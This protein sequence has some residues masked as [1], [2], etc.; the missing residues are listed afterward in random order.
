M[1]LEE[2]PKQTKPPVFENEQY[3]KITRLSHSYN[4][5]N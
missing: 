4:N 3:A 5:P 1:F 2:Y